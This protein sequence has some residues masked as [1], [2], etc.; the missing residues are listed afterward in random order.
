MRYEKN[1]LKSSFYFVFDMTVLFFLYLF[2]DHF[3]YFIWVN[4]TGFYM[5][6]LF[7][8]GHD[9]GHTTFSN[10]WL[11]NDIVGHICHSIIQVPYYPWKLSHYQH[12][13][14]HNNYKKDN[15]HEW[16]KKEEYTILDLLLVKLP[17][18]E[19][20]A[21]FLYLING[22]DGSHFYPGQLFTTNEEK[23]KC[24][25]SVACIVLFDLFLFKYVNLN[26]IL[27]K[28]VFPWMV[29]NF[30]LYMVTYLQHHHDS[31]TVFDDNEWNF[32]KGAEQ[33]IDRKYGFFIDELSHH[34]TDG[35]V[36]HHLY[37]TQIPHYHLKD[38]TKI[39]K[40]KLGDKYL[41]RDSRDFLLE[42]HRLKYKQWYLKN[43]NNNELTYAS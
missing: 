29:F 30:W 12:H 6:C 28:Y 42:F 11:I 17:F 14:Y 38:A 23:S 7:V 26:D 41:Y 35:H 33:T 22:K 25:I 9:C 2:Y 16:K 19:F 5:W 36:A 34:I 39:I 20:I 3:N 1:L 18:I 40:E 4:L 27:W 13:L 37:F 10:Y 24:V 21:F 8:I 43:G 15:S 31:T 32:A